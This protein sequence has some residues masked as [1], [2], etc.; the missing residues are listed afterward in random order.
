MGRCAGCSPRRPCGEDPPTAARRAAPRLRLPAPAGV[1]VAKPPRSG[2]RPPT[3]RRP[4]SPPPPPPRGRGVSCL[5]GASVGAGAAAGARD[6]RG[7][8]EALGAEELGARG[9]AASSSC[10]SGPRRPAAAAGAERRRGRRPGQQRAC[11]GSGS[12]HRQLPAR[13]QGRQPQ[14]HYSRRPGVRRPRRRRPRTAPGLQ[15]KNRRTAR[16]AGRAEEPE[17]EEAGRR[18]RRGWVAEGADVQ[19]PGSGGGTPG[20]ASASRDPR[21]LRAL[22]RNCRRRCAGPEETRRPPPLPR[23]TAPPDWP[24][25]HCAE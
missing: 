7:P 6:A 15:E 12:G 18:R 9:R 10:R 22:A 21:G 3:L 20:P 23:N 1:Q 19:G 13:P 16:A 11:S 25:P 5:R 17:E 2:S 4:A 14:Q 8:A 24:A